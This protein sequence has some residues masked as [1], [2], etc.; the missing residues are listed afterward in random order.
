[1]IEYQIMISFSADRVLTSEEEDN[2]IGHIVPQIEEPATHEG[3]DEE[4]STA[5]VQIALTQKTLTTEA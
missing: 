4:Y 2:L 1:M 5:K 3:D